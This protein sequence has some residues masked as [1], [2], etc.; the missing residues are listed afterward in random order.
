MSN[1]LK[2]LYDRNGRLAI[3]SEVDTY[4]VYVACFPADYG[5]SR[6]PVRRLFDVHCGSPFPL[7]GFSWAWVGRGDDACIFE[8][9]C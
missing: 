3:Y 4:A 2:S 7:A 8:K 5:M 1:S 6:A 9:H